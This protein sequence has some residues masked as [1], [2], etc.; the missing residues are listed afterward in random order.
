MSHKIVFDFL[1]GP[2]GFAKELQAGFDGRIFIETI[3]ANRKS[4]FLETVRLDQLDQDF[5]ECYSVQYLMGFIAHDSV[6]PVS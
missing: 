6:G 3:D 2:R 1:A 4:E 5:L